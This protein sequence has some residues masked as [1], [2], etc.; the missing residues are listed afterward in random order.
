MSAVSTTFATFPGVTGTTQLSQ[1]IANLVLE[2][3]TVNKNRYGP[4]SDR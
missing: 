3:K 2:A 4:S 1:F